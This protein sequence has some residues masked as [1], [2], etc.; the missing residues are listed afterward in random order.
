MIKKLPNQKSTLTSTA[1]KYESVW[2]YVLLNCV[3]PRIGEGIPCTAEKHPSNPLEE[4][5]DSRLPRILPFCTCLS[6]KWMPLSYTFGVA[7]CTFILL[8]QIMMVPLVRI[9]RLVRCSILTST[10]SLILAA[11]ASIQGHTLGS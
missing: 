5:P 2:M 7:L 6:N 3:L 9:V 1:V 10:Q 4:C 11:M 8:L